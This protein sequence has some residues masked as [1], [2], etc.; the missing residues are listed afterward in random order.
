MVRYKPSHGIW[1]TLPANCTISVFKLRQRGEISHRWC[2]SRPFNYDHKFIDCKAD[3]STNSSTTL[4][5]AVS[6]ATL[7]PP[8]P[9]ATAY[10]QRSV[11]DRRVDSHRCH[12]LEIL[13]CPIQNLDEKDELMWFKGTLLHNVPNSVD[14]GTPKLP[15]YHSQGFTITLKGRT[16][17]ALSAF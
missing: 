14:T 4:R 13:K 9:K 17:A 8:S 7:Y 5:R 2:H 12:I 1:Q 16:P 15:V 6:R 3:G 11:C 10:T